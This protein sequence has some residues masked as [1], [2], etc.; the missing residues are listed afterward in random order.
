MTV[1]ATDNAGFSGQVVFS[2]TIASA[3]AFTSAAS[4]SFTAGTASAFTV[5]AAGT[6]TPALSENGTLPSGVS[7]VDNGDGTGS[8]SGTAAAGS[9]GSYPLQLSAASS[10]GMASQSFTLT[11]QPALATTSV[12]LSANPSAYGAASC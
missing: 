8:L 12:A 5:T 7:F 2:W 6:P 1:T 3:P 10:A 4:A 11:V 9:A